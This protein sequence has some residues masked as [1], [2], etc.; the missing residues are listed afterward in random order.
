M[1]NNARSYLCVFIAGLF[2]LTLCSCNDAKDAEPLKQDISNLVMMGDVQFK[3]ESMSGAERYNKE[4]LANRNPRQALKKMQFV[5]I[6]IRNDQGNE[7]SESI[8]DPVRDI[9]LTKL[10]ESLELVTVYQEAH[11]EGKKVERWFLGF[12]K[13]VEDAIGLELAINYKDYKRTIRL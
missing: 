2:L 8:I 4:H 1:K 5:T 13:Q 6:E 3:I 12:D 9:I 7:L 11:P 10:G